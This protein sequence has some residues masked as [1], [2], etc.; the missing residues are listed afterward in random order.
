VKVIILQIKLEKKQV[1]L[2]F[3]PVYEK[4]TDKKN[5]FSPLAL[6]EAKASL[7]MGGINKYSLSTTDVTIGEGKTTT[8]Y[9]GTGVNPNAWQ[10]NQGLLDIQKKFRKNESGVE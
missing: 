1:A 6:A 8:T 9:K 7:D 3:Q 4:Y 2:G 10:Q 5:D